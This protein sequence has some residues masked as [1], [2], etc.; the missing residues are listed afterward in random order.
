MVRRG[1]VGSG[2][3]CKGSL[4]GGREKQWGLTTYACFRK[5]QEGSGTVIKGQVGSGREFKGKINERERKA[6]GG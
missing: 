6:K 1:Q 3:E 5:A 4:K 2:R